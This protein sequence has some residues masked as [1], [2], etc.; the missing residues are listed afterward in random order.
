MVLDIQ[1][2]T[3]DQPAVVYIETNDN[4]KIVLSGKKYNGKNEKGKD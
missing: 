2:A 1:K 4:I 3:A